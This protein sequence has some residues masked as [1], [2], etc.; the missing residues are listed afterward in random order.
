MKRTL[1]A[2]TVAITLT[3]TIAL[4]AAAQEVQYT[5]RPNNEM[6]DGPG[7]YYPLLYVFPPGIPLTILKKEGGWFQSRVRGMDSANTSLAG[8]VSKYCLVDKTPERGARRREF[9]MAD[10]KASPTSVA[11]AI[12]GFALR[13]GKTDAG[14]VDILMKVQAARFPPEEYR[15]F[16]SET[17]QLALNRDVKP[18]LRKRYLDEYDVTIDE[19]GVG[20]G[21]A[22]HIANS[23]LT[24]NQRLQK[25]LNLV[26]TLLGEASG[27][28]DIPVTVLVLKGPRV[29]AL[30]LP[31]GF[32]F[33]SERLIAL[34]QNEADLASVLAH[35]MMHI[36]MKHGV[37]EIHE[38]ILNV[39]MDAAMKE[40]EEEVGG[41]TDEAEG[42]LEDLAAESY[43][44]V[45]NPR[46]QAYELEA[47]CGAALVLARAGYD[48]MA[49][50]GMIR[51]IERTVMADTAVTEGNPFAGMDFKRRYEAIVPFINDELSDVKGVLN[52]GRFSLYTK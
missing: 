16:R 52:A 19:R 14:S 29:T 30:A 13:Y 9:L 18:D 35:E 20:L 43:D 24:D 39:K 3:F 27:A 36:V 1:I 33:V 17:G 10:P 22:A 44:V 48:P 50:A 2:F 51:R 23:G 28:Y 45:V 8:W 37:K 32:I 21:V 6:R 11:A 34:C 26:A 7:N 40:L 12:R 15:R 38:R 46:L 5:K 4:P 25:Y 41:E 42:D 49:L 31:G 47:D